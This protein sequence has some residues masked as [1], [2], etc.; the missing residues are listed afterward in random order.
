VRTAAGLGVPALA[1]SLAV[2]AVTAA[3]GTGDAGA[4]FPGSNG[5]I[6]FESDRSGAGEIFVMDLDG[7]NQTPIASADI[8]RPTYSADGERIAF[9]NDP[10]GDFEIFVM[11]GDGQ[12][13][14]QLTSNTGFADSQPTFAPDG[15]IAF[16]SNRDGDEEIFVMDADGQNQTRL[17]FNSTPPNETDARPAFSPD[18]QRIAFTSERDGDNEIFVMDA[19]GQNQTQLTFNAANDDD[20]TFSPDG[21]RIA[22]T[23]NRDGPDKIFLMDAGGQNQAPLTPDALGDEPAFSPD[24]QSIAFRSG[25][26]GDDEI[27]VVP[28]SGGAQIPL[29]ANSANDAFPDWQPLNPP[30]CDLSAQQKQ[31]SAKRITATALCQNENASLIVAGSLRVPKPPK[32]GAAVAKAKVF[33]LA[34]VSVEV[35]PGQ[36]AAIELTV[37]K[38]ARKK[39]KAAFAA[40]KKGTATLTATASDDLGASTED[41]QQ[42]K[43]K[44]R[45]R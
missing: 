26:G 4:A 28:A 2:A 42:V 25:L 27:V 13:L 43:L 37:P 15:R 9:Q 8:G 12:N 44:K 32:A 16:N 17:T 33:E 31:K 20:A 30:A 39:L 41:A 11:D 38:S 19:D 22:F 40:G 24:G 7:Q 23:S 1:A 5:K 36:A 21:T 6:A 45:K 3:V 18:G 29:T 34:P 35:Q 10:D 14:V